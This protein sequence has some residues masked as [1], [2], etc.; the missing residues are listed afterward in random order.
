MTRK[1]KLDTVNVI[2]LVMLALITV[3]L[4]LVLALTTATSATATTTT[5]TGTIVGQVEKAWAKAGGAAKLGDPI[6]TETKIRVTGRNTYHQHTL[7]GTVY[8]DGSQ[9]GKTWMAGKVPALSG[10][11]NERDALAG[12]GLRPGVVYRTAKL[13]KSS[14]GADRLLTS[15]LHG[16]TIIDL[17]TSGTAAGC[18]D[19]SLP[20]VSKAR[21]SMTATANPETFVTKA[22]D[23]KSVASALRKIANT[24]GPVLLHCTHGR[25]RTGWIVSVLLMAA[26]EDLGTVRTE[27]LKSPGVKASNLDKGI[28]AMHDNFDGVE[29][30][31]LDGLGL[32]PSEV[33]ALQERI[34]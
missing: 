21:Y 10:V 23:R 5:P 32:S 14:T 13:C 33:A 16:G 11:D 17:R 4:A 7:G 28:R 8:W 6:G 22:S 20:Q 34:S 24:D 3:A 29:G 15:M 26:G 31:M 19:P 1:S 9:G 25:D 12:A 27:Y 2:E 30:Y 18:P